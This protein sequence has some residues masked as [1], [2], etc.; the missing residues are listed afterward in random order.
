MFASRL[1]CRVIEVRWATPS[2]FLV[3]FEPSRSFSFLPGQFI[4]VVVPT[5][6]GPVKRCYSLASSPQESQAQNAYELCIKLVP[7]GAGSTYLSKFRPGS[8]FEAFAPYGS[9]TYKPAARGRGVVFIC[10]GSGIAPF[11]SVA[12]SHLFQQNRPSHSLLLYGARDEREILY[13]RDFL[14]LGLEMVVAVSNPSPSW[15]GFSGRVTDYLASLGPEFPWHQTDFYLCGN[16][17][18]VQDVCA[19]LQGGLG[20]S[21]KHIHRENFSPVK[22]LTQPEPLF[23][24]IEK[25]R[26][27]AES[28][29]Q[30]TAA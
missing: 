4:S 13:E 7:G 19:L 16:G 21:E 27:T 10:T 3:R 1:K 8:E 18:M 30:K 26:A 20:V 29:E 22:T 15:K 14:Q 9:F 25:K 5:P 24:P 12:A 28:V 2:V 17:Q 11:R 6:S 23:R